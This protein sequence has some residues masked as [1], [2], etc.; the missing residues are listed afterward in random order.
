MKN[1]VNIN[2]KRKRIFIRMKILKGVIGS[3]SPTYCLN[4][5]ICQPR[6]V[7]NGRYIICHCKAGYGGARCERRLHLFSFLFFELIFFYFKN[8]SVV[9]RLDILLMNFLK[10]KENISGVFLITMV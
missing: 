2:K 7:G 4:E 1:K 6:D 9:D 8:T 3:C 10:I 5:G